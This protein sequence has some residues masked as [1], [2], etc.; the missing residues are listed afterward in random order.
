MRSSN[1]TGKFPDRIEFQTHWVENV[2]T[3]ERVEY[4]TVPYAEH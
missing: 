2:K 4:K 1:Y 3:G